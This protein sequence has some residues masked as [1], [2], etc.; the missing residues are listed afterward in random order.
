MNF[1]RNFPFHEPSSCLRTS[2]LQLGSPL[3]CVHIHSETHGKIALTLFFP[4]GFLWKTKTIHRIL[5]AVIRLRKSLEQV[6]CS[7]PQLGPCLRLYIM[8][9]RYW[10]SIQGL[11]LFCYCSK[12]RLK[13]FTFLSAAE[14]TAQK[15]DPVPLTLFVF[16]K[17]L[18]S[19]AGQR[20]LINSESV[21]YFLLE[22]ICKDQR[23]PAQNLPA[24]SSGWALM[25]VNMSSS[26]W[27]QC[28]KVVS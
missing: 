13:L 26:S 6:G 8:T 27:S 21:L 19:L 9:A 4:P 1:P 11:T 3:S 17:E 23:G 2:R 5:C 18:W 24:F 15:M 22:G 14:K 12:E 28:N 10:C 25:N 20:C 7:N 16:A